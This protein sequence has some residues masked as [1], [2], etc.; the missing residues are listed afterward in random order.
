[1]TR[2]QESILPRAAERRIAA[3]HRHLDLLHPLL[4]GL[5]SRNL[6]SSE[7]ER[8]ITPSLF[9]DVKKQEQNFRMHVPSE[10]KK[11]SWNHR[12]I[13]QMARKVVLR[14]CPE[15]GHF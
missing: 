2:S 15:T 9:T 5:S 6:Q 10:G 13:P 8:C 11:I 3:F 14:E 7:I 12:F 1:V 4:F